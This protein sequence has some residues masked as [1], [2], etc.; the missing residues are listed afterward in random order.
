MRKF[1]IGAAMALGMAIPAAAQVQVPS[2]LVN[3][4]VGNVVLENILTDVEITAL[5]DNDVLNNNQIQ[6][7]VPIG[8]AA[9]VCGISAAVIGKSSSDPVCTANNS[10]RSNALAQHIRKQHLRGN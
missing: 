8:S 6:V 9:N 2:G 10:T 3:V 1:M 7:A 4:T 5:N